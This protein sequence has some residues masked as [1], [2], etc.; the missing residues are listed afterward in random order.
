MMSINS[1]G[2]AHLLV[3]VLVLAALTIGGFLLISSI[4]RPAQELKVPDKIASARVTGNAKVIEGEGVDTPRYEESFTSLPI[5]KYGGAVSLNL[6]K[7]GTVYL[8]VPYDT[9]NG[10]F[11]ELSEFSQMP[12]SETHV[13]L[14]EDLGYGIN[15]A[16]TDIAGLPNPVFL[17]F[18]FSDGKRLEEFKKLDESLINYCDYSEGYFSPEICQTLLGV[19]AD[20][21][22]GK[23]YIA[24]SPKRADDGRTPTFPLYSYYLGADDIL[25]LRIDLFNESSV[26][27][28]PQPLTNELATDIVQSTF[29][30]YSVEYEEYEAFG[31]AHA[32]GLTLPEETLGTMVVHD[33]EFYEFKSY[34]A[35]KY[36]EGVVKNP[37][38]LGFLQDKNSRA[39]EDL[40]SFFSQGIGETVQGS[41]RAA[42]LVRA[43]AANIAGASEAKSKVLENLV[44]GLNYQDYQ[45]HE[46]VHAV[47]SVFILTNE[48]TP[49]DQKTQSAARNEAEKEIDR[50][51][52]PDYDPSFDELY[53]AF[54]LTDGIKDTKAKEEV[55]AKTEEQLNKEILNAQTRDDL[56]RLAGECALWGYDD[57]EGSLCYE[58]IQEVLND[59]EGRCYDILWGGSKDLSG[60]IK[61]SKGLQEFGKNELKDDLYETCKNLLYKS[62]FD[63]AHERG[64]PLPR[65]PEL[66]PFP[67][68]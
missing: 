9:L 50:V 29:G 66:P 40:V 58:L 37:R 6:K 15:V 44:T 59:I 24:V 53:N 26:M 51:T 47:E 1:R 18:D 30:K 38:D 12:T 13:P 63:I 55:V 4:K 41:E 45:D 49:E 20:K 56:Y 14:Y 46:L 35:G 31:L 16:F 62:G 61:K 10:D 3:I 54:G 19:P 57:D 32:L 68:Q 42:N 28:I 36:L 67:N 23:K 27:V 11:A 8:T 52:D 65:A 60:L 33:L 43:Q 64:Y 25:V 34:F 21:T 5:S 39:A 48:N 7:G 17:V 2:I 22:V